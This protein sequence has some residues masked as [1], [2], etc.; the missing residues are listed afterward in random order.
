MSIQTQ[1][2]ELTACRDLIVSNLATKGVTASRTENLRTLADKILQ[3]STGRSTSTTI[4]SGS[5]TAVDEY[6]NGV[7]IN[8]NSETLSLSDFISKYPAFC[9]SENDYSLN[10]TTD[11]MGWN[12]DGKT[13]STT[14]L[15]VSATSQIIITYLSGSTQPGIFKLVKNE[16][17]AQGTELADEIIV[18]A[19]T[20]GKYINIPF[21]LVY[22]AEYVTMVLSCTGVEAGTYY[23]YW[24]GTSD[25]SHP[26]I[27]NITVIQ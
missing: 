21:S 8:F 4:Y 12:Q 13:C 16:T 20:D 7:F 2:E 27:K 19:E 17:S 15:N 9:N 25:N 6:G 14:A 1:L 23:P 11:F 26:K 22:N 3:I 18:N 10:Y 5:E 24:V